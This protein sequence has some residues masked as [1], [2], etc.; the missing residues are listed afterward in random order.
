MFWPVPIP[1]P[2]RCNNLSACAERLGSA[3]QVLF[4]HY[5][6]PGPFGHLAADFAAMPDTTVWFA[7][8]YGR[9]DLSVPGV[10]RLNL[11]MP[12]AGGSQGPLPPLQEA[13]RDF[14]RAYLRG[15]MTAG[16]LW[17]LRKTGFVPDMICTT[18]AMGNSLFLR[19][20]FPESFCVVHAETFSRRDDGLEGVQKADPARRRIRNVLHLNSLVDCDL[21]VTSTRY[22]RDQFPEWLAKDMVVL[23]RCVD[24]DFF[25]PG[26]GREAFGE[27][28]T[29]SGQELA[30]PGAFPLFD[31]LSGLLAKRS[32]CRAAVLAPFVG[33][34]QL[35]ALREQLAGKL[36]KYAERVLLCGFSSAEAYRDVLRAS[37]LYIH[38][39]AA[40]VSLALLES[41]SCGCLVLAS[42]T[43][44]VR[45]FVRE[46][47]N[48]F[49]CDF[50][51]AEA[52]VNRIAALLER[53]ACLAGVRK[54][55][56]KDMMDGHNLRHT[57]K[58]N[59]ECLLG[60]YARWRGR[61]AS[62]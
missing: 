59:R 55:A 31:I 43:E 35:P 36:G 23:P 15:H 62:M 56:R 51:S 30:S 48:G 3:M 58:R 19:D 17:K 21:A 44:A 50:C 47:E 10:L 18:A 37:S 41:M 49:L 34:A 13:G 9:R 54:A 26:S 1:H 11:R 53:R 2:S 60:H 29:F 57:L 27:L 33:R 4:V 25:S 61:A 45:E 52:T 39:A 40:F 24:T 28:V 42:D 6:F 8:E 14:H 7:S 38:S 5:A 20:I 32:T 46:G 12:K 16:E 22:Q